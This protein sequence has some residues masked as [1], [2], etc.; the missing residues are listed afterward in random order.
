M[1]TF[2]GASRSD[3]ATPSTRCPF[4]GA[5]CAMSPSVK[6]MSLSS[7]T[8]PGPDVLRWFFETLR[9]TNAS[10]S[11]LSAKSV[12]GH[13][14]GNWS[15]RRRGSRQAACHRLDCFR[16][17]ATSASLWARGH[18]RGLGDDQTHLFLGGRRIRRFSVETHVFIRWI[19][20]RRWHRATGGER[21]EHHQS[22]NGQRKRGRSGAFRGS[23]H[24]VDCR[25]TRIVR[26]KL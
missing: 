18:L 11:S 14:R 3:G 7:T 26:S 21:R 4:V 5:S 22:Q 13:G 20:A 23:S 17:S 10:Q 19:S 24:A 15:P 8:F 1:R 6:F 16:H 9:R 25:A 2:T 12:G